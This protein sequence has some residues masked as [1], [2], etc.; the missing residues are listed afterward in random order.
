MERRQPWRTKGSS[1]AILLLI[2]LAALTWATARNWEAIKIGIA[3]AFS[4]HRPALLRDAEWGKPETASAF[5][6]R[7]PDGSSEK[8]LLA[9]LAANHFG[10]DQAAHRA[11]R[12]VR[13]YPCNERI[14]VSWAASD[15]IVLQSSAEVS[16]G[17]C[18]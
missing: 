15:G 6:H 18:L 12:T 5:H 13:A 2:L 10:I 1:L 11:E 9:W 14:E 4:E 17:G 8:D 7:F 16:E 3:V